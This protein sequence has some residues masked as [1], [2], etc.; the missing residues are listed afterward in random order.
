[1]QERNLQQND[2]DFRHLN[3]DNQELATQLSKATEVLR[4]VSRKYSFSTFSHFGVLA[5]LVH[6][7]GGN[8]DEVAKLLED[9]QYSSSNFIAE[10]GYGNCVDFA[11]L[12]QKMLENVGV[13][14]SI[15]GALPDTAKY[16]ERQINFFR[17][18]HTSLLYVN[19]SK[20]TKIFMFEPGWKIPQPIV[21]NLGIVSGNQDWDFETIATNNFTFTQKTLNKNKNKY[22]KRT[23]DL[24]QLDISFC[25]SLTKN[26]VRIPRK[27]EMLN[28]L[29]DGMPT[30][31]IRFDPH[32]RIFVTNVVGIGGEFLPR[33][34]SNSQCKVLETSLEFPGL[35]DYLNNI[36]EFYMSL[37]QN[38]WVT[39]EK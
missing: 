38:F 32:K 26:L 16:T 36:F 12:T 21:V 4:F 5:E 35:V 28:R 23:F 10:N 8:P 3:V 27:L 24:H 9:W 34:L 19:A 30:Y 6:R 2:V 15:I 18:R 11:V 25:T 13:P 1:M 7:N 37:P 20:E 29:E 33:D 17:Y 22:S 31:L 14:T 39:G